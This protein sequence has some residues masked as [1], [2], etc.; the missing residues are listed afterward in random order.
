[1]QSSELGRSFLTRVS[2]YLVS[3]PF[4]LKILQEAIAEPDLDR[5]VR[6]TACAVLINALSPQEGASPER[7]V[8]DVLWL[9]MALGQILQLSMAGNEGAEAFCDRFEDVFGTVA[10]DLRLFEAYLGP[11]LW[12]WLCGKLSTLNRCSLKGKRPSQYVNDEAAW[13]GLYEDGL[14]FQTDYDVTED[15]VQNRLRRP[16]QIIEFLQ[17]RHAE[18]CKKRG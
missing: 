5:G 2:E 16:E 4:D 17:K 18:D 3:F 10:A 14:D 12:T 9:R 1:M 8:D 15:K 6:E 7:Y 13:D 11:E